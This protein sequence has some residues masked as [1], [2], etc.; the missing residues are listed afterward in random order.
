MMAGEA[1]GAVS[2]IGNIGVF[3]YNPD[4]GPVLVSTD[5][6]MDTSMPL[7]HQSRTGDAGR[8][9]RSF[10]LSASFASPP[11]GEWHSLLRH[12]SNRP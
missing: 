9:S 5:R 10:G 4:E 3:Q 7:G 1:R 6:P 11:S 12:R 2:L 8:Y